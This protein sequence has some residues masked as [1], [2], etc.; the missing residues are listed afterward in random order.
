MLGKVAVD[1]AARMVDN[2]ARL[3][4]AGAMSLTHS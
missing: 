3:T 2:G 4:H 1:D